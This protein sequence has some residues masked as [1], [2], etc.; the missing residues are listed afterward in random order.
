MVAAR[1]LPVTIQQC[2]GRQSECGSPHN[3]ATDHHCAWR[4]AASPEPSALWQEPS[5]GSSLPDQQSI[6]NARRHGVPIPKRDTNAA[7][8]GTGGRPKNEVNT[9]STGRTGSGMA[10]QGRG[11]RAAMRSVIMRGGRGYSWAN[12]SRRCHES[13]AKVI[14]T[15]AMNPAIAPMAA[16]AGRERS[17]RMSLAGKPTRSAS[18][19]P[20]CQRPCG[21]DTCASSAAAA[22]RPSR[23]WRAPAA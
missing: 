23:P 20:A 3:V 16:S 11:A 19:W 6:G 21:A 1:F 10:R 9:K 18:A 5:P 14:G 4:A 13:M 22:A 17:I 12:G 2:F 7:V 8:K 15:A